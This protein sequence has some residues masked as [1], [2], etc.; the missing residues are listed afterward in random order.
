MQNTC[1][2]LE[3][4]LHCMYNQNSQLIVIVYNDDKNLTDGKYDN[5][6]IKNA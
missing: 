1:I 4:V 3:L 6:Q 5:Y 2:N